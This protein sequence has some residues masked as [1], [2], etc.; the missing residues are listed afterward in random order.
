[1]RNRQAVGSEVRYST[2]L[3]EQTFYYAM[4]P[5]RRFCDPGCKNDRQCAEKYGVGDLF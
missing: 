2:T 3:D 4:V 1:M 5:E